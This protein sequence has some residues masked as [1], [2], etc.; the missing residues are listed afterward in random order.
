MR[1]ADI[2]LLRLR[3]LF[4]RRQVEHELDEELCYH[5]E[6]QIE[7]GIAAGMTPENAR[8]AALQS[9]K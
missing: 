3:S 9:I 5:L 1:L 2:L 7:E 4:S 6:R 8:Y